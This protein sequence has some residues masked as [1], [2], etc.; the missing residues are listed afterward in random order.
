MI[1][2]WRTKQDGEKPLSH[3][4]NNRRELVISGTVPDAAKYENF[5]EFK[6]A[7]VNQG[8]RF[9]RGLSEKMFI[10]S[11]GRPLEPADHTTIDTLVTATKANE[12]SVRALIKAIATSR[13][14]Q[15]K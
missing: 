15:T 8:D 2:G 6:Q 7:L 14:F 4:R 5:T 13:A 11:L 1:G 10:Y 3:W 12:H 9:L